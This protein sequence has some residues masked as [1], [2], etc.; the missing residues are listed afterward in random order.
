MDIAARQVIENACRTLLAEYAV[1]VDT[2]DAASMVVLF[3]PDGVLRRGELVLR[4]A[5]ELPKILGQRKPDVVMR[6][7]L[8]TMRIRVTDAGH[9]EGLTYY[10][11][12]SGRG[13]GLPLPMGEPFSLGDWHSRF[14]LTS[15]GWKFAEQ[16]I[17]RV[18][19]GK[20]AAGAPVVTAAAA[21]R[22][23]P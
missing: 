5:A 22:S 7:L 19:V 18:F 10:L 3:A 14:V 13:A 12:H 17:A 2:G 16:E 11:L 4:G 8:T 1:A 21:Q 15:E 23:T 6:H 20:A 9:A